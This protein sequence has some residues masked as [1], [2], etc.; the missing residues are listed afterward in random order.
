MTSTSIPIK[1]FPNEDLTEEVMCGAFAFYQGLAVGI[2]VP[3][4]DGKQFVDDMAIEATK[5]LVGYMRSGRTLGEM[6]ELI[7]KRLDVMSKAYKEAVKDTEDWKLMFVNDYFKDTNIMAKSVGF[8]SSVKSAGITLFALYVAMAV[9]LKA[10]PED[11]H[12]GFL[13]LSKKSKAS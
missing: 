2:P 13:I 5:T 4:H 12:N 8:D 11:N 10:I 1:S 7:K 9:K 3:P 6:K